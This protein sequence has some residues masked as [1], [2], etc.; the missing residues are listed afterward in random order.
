[1]PLSFAESA[2]VGRERF[3][4]AASPVP[5]CHKA[6][7]LF[8]LTAGAPLMVSYALRRGRPLQFEVGCPGIADP[9][10]GGPELGGVKELTQWYNRRLEELIRR[11]PGQ[12]WWVHR[13]WKG[14]PP[15]RGKKKAA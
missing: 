4:R 11:D 2:G 8:T 5:S 6:I 9:K 3:H 1:M 13:R 12:Y 10:R 15:Q 7:A 14:K